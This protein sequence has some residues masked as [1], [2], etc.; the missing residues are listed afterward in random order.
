[1][2]M[3]LLVWNKS[4]H[5]LCVYDYVTG[6]CVC[7]CVCVR[8]RG[9]GGGREGGFI[10]LKWVPALHEYSVTPRVSTDVSLMSACVWENELPW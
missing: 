1:M 5:F 2:S 6:L 10:G 7:V 8:E 4:L 3:C 9:A